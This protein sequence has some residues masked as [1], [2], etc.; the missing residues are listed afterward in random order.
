MPINWSECCICQLRI[1]ES[2]RS[3]AQGHEA[4]AKILPLFA[5]LNELGFDISRL[6]T[7]GLTLQESLEQNHA[8]YHHSCRTKYNQQKL[9]RAKQRAKKRSEPKASSEPHNPCKRLRKDDDSAS[10]GIFC[11]FCREEDSESNL[12]AAGTM[13]ASTS[14]T[15]IE[16]VMTITQK[17]KDM[18]T[19]IGDDHLIRILSSGDVAS[20][21]FFYH[22]ENI[23]PCLPNFHKKY[24]TEC[25]NANDTV[26]EDDTDWLK[27]C[28][29]DKVYFYMYESEIQ[30]KSSMFIVK[31]LENMYID[32]LQ[33]HNITVSSHVS[34][35]SE[36]LITRYESLEKK[37]LINKL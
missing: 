29:L 8:V 13:H 25:K 10:H 28:A 27:S 21:E 31:D 33:C 2:L 32:L 7:T 17:W 37:K 34:R 22:K 24:Q 5:E 19:K 18:A 14:K 23:K 3:T 20:N 26:N 15:N 1:K 6:D 12:R 36:D 30:K 16:H 4:L 35:F 11:C 9:D